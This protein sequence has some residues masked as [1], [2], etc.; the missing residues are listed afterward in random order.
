MHSLD[1][2]N[3][4][5]DRIFAWLSFCI[6]ADSGSICHPCAAMVLSSAWY[7]FLFTTGLFYSK[8]SSL[9]LKHMHM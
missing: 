1:H 6:K 5:T 3:G 4:C 8:W 9:F 2:E 7:Y